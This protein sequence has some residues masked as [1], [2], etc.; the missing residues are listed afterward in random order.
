M[1]ISNNENSHVMLTSY[2]DLSGQEIYNEMQQL[3]TRGIHYAADKAINSQ[4]KFSFNKDFKADVLVPKNADESISEFILCG[5][6]Q[7]DTQKFFMTS[8]GKWNANNMISTHFEQV[9]LSCHLLPVQH[10]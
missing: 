9:K 4:Y 10:E 2:R 7:I 8:D 5:V 3:E 1:V 6:F